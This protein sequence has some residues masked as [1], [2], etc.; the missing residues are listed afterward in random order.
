MAKK[1]LGLEPAQP[2]VDEAG[3]QAVAR[4]DR[5]DR[6]DSRR[7]RPVILPAVDDRHRVGPVRDHAANDSAPAPFVEQR[8]HIAV[9][10]RRACARWRAASRRLS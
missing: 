4:S 5:V 6:G 7:D 8:G 2:A 1:R 9:G 10:S 3:E